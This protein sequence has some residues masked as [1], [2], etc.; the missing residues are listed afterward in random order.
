MVPS[1]VDLM[2]VLKAVLLA[3][4]LVASKVDLMA[5]SKVRCSVDW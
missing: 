4:S 2:A 1:K 3:A 5:A